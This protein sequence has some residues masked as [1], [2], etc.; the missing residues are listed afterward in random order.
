MSMLKIKRKGVVI[1][2]ICFFSAVALWIGSFAIEPI[3][4]VL[5]SR[6]TTDEMQRQLLYEID[7]IALASELRKF[8]YERRWHQS[9]AN[10]EPA[11]FWPHDAA[12]PASIQLLQP[13]SVAV[14]DD[15]IM[16]ERGGPMLHFGI[17]VFRDG[18]VG[19]GQKELSPGVWFY[20]DNGRVPS[21]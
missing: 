18:I 7:H 8:A 11:V 6:K 14:F 9:S 10:V 5:Q 20:S 16:F 21:E 17:V 15:R 19:E 13:T 4:F 1:I 12:L 2:A 3:R